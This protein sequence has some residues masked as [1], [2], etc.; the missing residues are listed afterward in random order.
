[1]SRLNGHSPTLRVPSLLVEPN[2]WI[3]MMSTIVLTRRAQ[4]RIQATV[5]HPPRGRLE[6]VADCKVRTRTASQLYGQRTQRTS[7]TSLP[8]TK[9]RVLRGNGRGSSSDPKILE[10]RDRNVTGRTKEKV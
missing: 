7:E 4:D 1:M 10:L 2:L 5:A 9:Y 6:A 8:V 3:K